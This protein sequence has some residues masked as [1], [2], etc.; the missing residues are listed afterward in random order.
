VDA[1]LPA[2]KTATAVVISVRLFMET[3]LVW[4]G[5]KPARGHS[6][7][8]ASTLQTANGFIGVMFRLPHT[9]T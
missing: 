9:N 6:Q 4:A 2:A 8:A 5:D 7:A 1:K 3:L